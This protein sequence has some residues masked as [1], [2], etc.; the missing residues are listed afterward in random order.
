MNKSLYGFFPQLFD[1]LTPLASGTSQ[2]WMEGGIPFLKEIQQVLLEFAFYLSCCLL[3]CHRGG[4][5]Q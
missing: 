2:L 3:N 4:R 1:R 5:A